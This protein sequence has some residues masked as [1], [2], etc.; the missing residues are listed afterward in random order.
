FAAGV[1]ALAPS[2]LAIVPDRVV[3][4]R[5]HVGT[6]VQVVVRIEM[7]ANRLDLLRDGLACLVLGRIRQAAW[8]RG[9]LSIARNEWEEWIPAARGAVGVL[10]EVAAGVELRRGVAPLAPAELAEVPDRVA[11]R[12]RDIGIRRQVVG[13]VE[14]AFDGLDFLL[15][16]FQCKT[17]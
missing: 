15:D 17:P 13:G 14:A 10:G 4:R 9:R 12:A 5:H 2:V 7:R 6:G 1:S 3:L 11:A 16:R 8:A